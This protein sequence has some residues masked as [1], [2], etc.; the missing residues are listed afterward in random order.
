MVGKSIGGGY[1][2]KLAVYSNGSKIVGSYCMQ[3]T[4]EQQEGG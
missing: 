3:C 2:N 1:F 4:R